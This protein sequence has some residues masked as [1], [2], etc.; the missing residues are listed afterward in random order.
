M[1]VIVRNLTFLDTADCFPEWSPDDGPVGNWNSAY[2][3]ISIR[4]ATHVWIDHN[5]FA[6]LRVRDATQPAFFGRRYQVHDGLVDITNES[7]YV[8]VS[9]N[10][11][12]DHD[13][14][15]LIGNSDGALRTA[16]SCA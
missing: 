14:A 16:A 7:D 4:N 9:W 8:T 6:D 10:Q 1:N 12:A 13:K 2:D 5:R 15:M 3:S 11:F